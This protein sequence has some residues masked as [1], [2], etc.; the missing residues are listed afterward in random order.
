MKATVSSA[1]DAARSGNLLACLQTFYLEPEDT[2]TVEDVG[3]GSIDD[4]AAMS[5]LQPL[6]EFMCG[7][8]QYRIN[9]TYVNEDNLS[10]YVCVKVANRDIG[11]IAPQ[12]VMEFFILMLAA[13]LGGEEADIDT[14]VS[15]LVNLVTAQVG[16]NR[17]TSDIFIDMVKVNGIWKISP[18]KS[19]LDALTGGTVSVLENMTEDD[20]QFE[21]SWEDEEETPVETTTVSVADLLAQGYELTG[22]D[23]GM[24]KGQFWFDKDVSEEELHALQWDI[25]GYTVS[26]VRDR[27]DFTIDGYMGF[28][29][30]YIFYG[31]FNETSI[32]FTL[33]HSD[34][35]GLLDSIEESFPD[36]E[37]LDEF[38]NI[39]IETVESAYETFRYQ[40]TEETLTLIETNDEID[41]DYVQDNADAFFVKIPIRKD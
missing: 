37:E 24:G 17:Y 36:Y 19:L 25:E 28:G 34:I 4:L 21:P 20:F 40:M 32:S 6:I 9:Y 23:H 16:E 15:E 29:E 11:S 41:T 27:Y 8:L 1:L 39:V 30:A 12:F 18:N 31:T 5:E 3:L 38:Q 26:E 22:Y 2:E 14:M 35:E 33:K 7:S 10:G 13:G